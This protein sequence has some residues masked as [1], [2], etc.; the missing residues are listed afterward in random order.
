[1]RIEVLLHGSWQN[2]TIR[3]HG[4]RE[5]KNGLA[6]DLGTL[7]ENVK[8]LG[9]KPARQNSASRQRHFLVRTLAKIN[10]IKSSPV[11]YEF[12][13]TIIKGVHEKK[14]IESIA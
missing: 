1:M 6:R 9:L 14:D 3:E 5:R 7:P 12:R 2:E 13:T 11:E 8:K 4:R 10:I